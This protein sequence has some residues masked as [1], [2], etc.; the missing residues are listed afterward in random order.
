MNKNIKTICVFASASNNINEIYFKAAHELGVLIAQNRYDVIYGGSN[1]GLMGEVTSSA[2]L[3]GSEIIGVMPEKLYNLGINPG[4][5]SKFILTKGMR[6][7]K[8][9]M[10][11]LSQA[12]IALAG[13]FGTLE[14]LS[15]MIVQKQLGYNN[16]PIVLLN[17]NGFYNNLVNFFDDIIQQKFAPEI[18][19]DMYFVANTPEEALDYINSY[20]FSNNNYL[21]AKIGSKINH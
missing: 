1:L 17:T 13:G 20:D 10:D 16:K 18:C 21:D 5:C 2:R 12:L 7:R 19:K 9:K 15:E 6:E 11:E 14:E 8:A 4:E 3:R